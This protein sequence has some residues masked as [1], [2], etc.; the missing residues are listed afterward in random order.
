MPVSKRH[1]KR[2]QLAKERKKRQHA[3]KIA[4]TKV[5]ETAIYKARVDFLQKKLDKLEGKN[6][7]KEEIEEALHDMFPGA[8]IEEE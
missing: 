4:G 8:Q 3:E 5:L 2:R 6:E 1:P 7:V